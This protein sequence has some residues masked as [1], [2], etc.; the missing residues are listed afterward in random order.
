MVNSF[1]NSEGEDD[2]F[3]ENP[4]F[5]AHGFRG[6]VQLEVEEDDLAKKCLSML[7]RSDK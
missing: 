4:L 1:H 6:L 5:K 3:R 7:L 2:M